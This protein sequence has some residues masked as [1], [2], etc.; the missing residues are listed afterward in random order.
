MA[1]MEPKKVADITEEVTKSEK[2]I[3][4]KWNFFLSKMSNLY[5]KPL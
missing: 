1:F 5:W 3:P 2:K 4:T